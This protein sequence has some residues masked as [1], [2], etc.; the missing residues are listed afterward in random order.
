MEGR[1]EGTLECTLEM[2][3]QLLCSLLLVDMYS[4]MKQKVFSECY[5]SST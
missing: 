2:Y 1:G 4:G 3:A 5:A